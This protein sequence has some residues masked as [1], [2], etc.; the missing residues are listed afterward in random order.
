M[1]K[2][3]TE[4]EVPRQWSLLKIRVPRGTYIAEDPEWDQ[5]GAYIVFGVIPP[6]NITVVKTYM[7]TRFLS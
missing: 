7:G 2:F 1:E 5:P 4:K 3:F 6:Q